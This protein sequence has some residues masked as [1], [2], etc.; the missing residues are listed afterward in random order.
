MILKIERVLYATDLSENSFYAFRYAVRVARQFA[1][2]IIVLHVLEPVPGTF[3]E[4]VRRLAEDQK[5]GNAS[6]DVR[7][8]L[9]HFCEVV[10]KD[11]TCLDLVSNV[12]IR[13]G[14]PVEEILNTADEENCQMLILGTHGKGFLKHTFLGGVSQKVLDHSRKPVIVVPLPDDVRWD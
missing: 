2:K 7:N 14:Y 12:L 10:A 1:A 6:E 11:T 4:E 8:R 13:S 5:R 9:Q 3:G